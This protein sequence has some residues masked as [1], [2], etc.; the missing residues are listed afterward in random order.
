MIKGSPYTKDEDISSALILLLAMVCGHLPYYDDDV[1]KLIQKIAFSEL[2]YPSFVHPPLVELLKKIL[3][4]TP[5]TWIT[6]ENIKIVFIEDR[7]LGQLLLYYSYYRIV[8]RA[9]RDPGGRA[10]RQPGDKFRHIPLAIVFGRM[11]HYGIYLNLADFSTWTP[12]WI[13]RLFQSGRC[14]LDVRHGRGRESERGRADRDLRRALQGQQKDALQYQG[15]ADARA[16]R[17]RG[18]WG[19]RLPPSFRGAPPEFHS[20]LR[21]ALRDGCHWSVPR[22]G[23]ARNER[24]LEPAALPVD[25]LPPPGSPRSAR[26]SRSC[27]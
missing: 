5:E 8:A 17:P 9:E 25:Q 23:D 27:S 10:C 15:E 13:Y 2:K 3:S 7:V 21:R 24:L 6:L 20:V 22:P 19:D 26:L 18:P 14:D 16:L 11:I 1:K 12:T 4:K